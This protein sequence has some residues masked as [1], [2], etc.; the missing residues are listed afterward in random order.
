MPAALAGVEPAIV[1][2]QPEFAQLGIDRPSFQAQRVQRA[3]AEVQ[4]SYRI[5]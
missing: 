1:P 5:S 4:H 2:G 3:W